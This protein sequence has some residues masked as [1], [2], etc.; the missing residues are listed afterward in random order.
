MVN[1]DRLV[2]E[3]CQLVRIDSISKKEREMADCLKLKLTK[4]GFEVYEDDAGKKIGGNAGNLICT[5]KGAESLPSVLFMA[6]IDTVVPGIGKKPIVDGDYVKSD[7]KTVLGADDLAG[8]EIILEAMRCIKENNIEHGDI[9]V[10]FTVAE[11][12]G[13]LGSKNL[14]FS[15]IKSKFG[16]ILDSG[17]KGSVIV[18]APSENLIDIIVYGKAAHAGVEPENGVDAIRIA[19]EA[20]ANMKLGRIDF[21]TTSNIGIING[22]RATN[23]ICERVDLKGEARSRDDKKLAKQT[24]HMED[25]FKKAA[26]K[27][28]G[29]VD[30]KFEKCYSGYKIKKDE[31]VL[32]LFEKASKA[33]GVEANLI[34][35]NG[36]SDANIL[37][38]KGIRALNISM[39][40]EKYHTVNEVADINE[41]VKMA[42]LLINIVKDVKQM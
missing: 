24:E 28:D 39:G 35:M 13:L 32:R 42:Q 12:I 41:M 1:R 15:K 7:G 21:E 3:F 4:L 36:G 30:F 37:N 10:V 20:I 22:G 11:E 27:Y 23:I 17:S 14:D 19:S 31:P 26:E 29:K 16:F 5:L 40:A 6:H 34:S 25:C 38:E 2:E 9:E 33:S 18:G 8:V